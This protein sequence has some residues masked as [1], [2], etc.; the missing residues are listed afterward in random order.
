LLVMLEIVFPLHTAV[1]AGQA[2]LVGVLVV[3][4]LR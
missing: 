1:L 3:G 4:V 2:F